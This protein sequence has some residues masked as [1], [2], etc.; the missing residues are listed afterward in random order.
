MIYVLIQLP[1]VGHD[2]TGGRVTRNYLSIRLYDDP[3]TESL[4]G[5]I[6]YSR[7][8]HIQDTLLCFLHTPDTL[9][10]TSTGWE[11][12]YYIAEYVA[13]SQGILLT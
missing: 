4:D 2:V 9:A 5:G 13:T 6:K 3:S 7:S 10:I 11:G 8:S 12:T 1:G